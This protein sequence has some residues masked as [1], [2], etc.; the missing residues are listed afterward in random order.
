MSLNQTLNDSKNSSHD[1][2]ERNP[3][4]EAKSPIKIQDFD[5]YQA[6]LAQ[7]QPTK[8]RHNPREGSDP[9]GKQMFVTK[10]GLVGYRKV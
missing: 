4:N 5:R 3:W 9:H 7:N 8:V 6:I 1:D 10:T 2:K